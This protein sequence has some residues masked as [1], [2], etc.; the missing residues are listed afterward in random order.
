MEKGLGRGPPQ[1]KKLLEKCMFCSPGGE[2]LE[3][4]QFSEFTKRTTK[5]VG[6]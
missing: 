5:A 3:E 1:S 4:Y 6:L 2:S